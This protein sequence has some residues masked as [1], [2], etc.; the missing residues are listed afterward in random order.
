MPAKIEHM[1][2]RAR[3]PK[4]VI[5]RPAGQAIFR[6]TLVGEERDMSYQVEVAH[7]FEAP[8][9]ATAT[10]Q[11]HNDGRSL[12]YSQC[13]Q[14]ITTIG[15]EDRLSTSGNIVVLFCS[16]DDGINLWI[17]AEQGTSSNHLAS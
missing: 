14:V 13:G 15:I 12:R 9:K 17:L 6:M 8:S 10:S 11:T 2:T 16:S 1:E 5:V 3:A 7:A 4:L